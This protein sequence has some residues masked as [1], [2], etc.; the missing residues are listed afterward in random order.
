MKACNA[1]F[2]ASSVKVTVQSPNDE[3]LTLPTAPLGVSVLLSDSER[4]MQLS[5]KLAS[6]GLRADEIAYLLV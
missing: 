2:Q 4:Q 1:R 5:Q 3:S 6:L